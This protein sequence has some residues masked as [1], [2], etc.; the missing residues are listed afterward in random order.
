MFF[1]TKCPLLKIQIV[2]SSMKFI[3]PS[4]RR[5]KEVKYSAFGKLQ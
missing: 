5:G 3:P 1:S 4:V 2:S